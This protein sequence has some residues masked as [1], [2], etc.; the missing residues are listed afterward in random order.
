MRRR[1]LRRKKEA[2]TAVTTLSTVT[3][4]SSPRRFTVVPLGDEASVQVIA[5]VETSA[6]SYCVAAEKIVIIRE[7][8]DAVD[9]AAAARAH[10]NQRVLRRCVMMFHC[11][12]SPSPMHLGVSWS[13]V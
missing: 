11:T 7:D 3:T 9:V 13:G 6:A 10:R 8:V 1:R 4:E 5:P 12:C 2:S